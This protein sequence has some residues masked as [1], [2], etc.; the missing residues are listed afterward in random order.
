MA[1][2]NFKSKVF[3]DVYVKDG[4]DFKFESY[5]ND[6]L[7]GARNYIPIKY[8]HT[9][10]NYFS[11]IYAN[12]IVHASED[13]YAPSE[14]VINGVWRWKLTMADRIYDRVKVETVSGTEFIKTFVDKTREMSKLRLK[15]FPEIEP[16][17]HMDVISNLRYSI[18]KIISG[19]AGARLKIEGP[20]GLFDYDGVMASILR[21]TLLHIRQPHYSTARAPYVELKSSLFGSG[22]FNNNFRLLKSRYKLSTPEFPSN[23]Y[24]PVI[25]DMKINEGVETTIINHVFSDVET[26]KYNMSEDLLINALTKYDGHMIIEPCNYYIPLVEQGGEGRSNF[27]TYCPV[28]DDE[29]YVSPEVLKDPTVLLQYSLR[30]GEKGNINYEFVKDTMESINS[31]RLVNAATK[32]FTSLP[33]LYGYTLPA[34]LHSSL[35]LEE[36]QKLVSGLYNV[37]SNA[38]KYDAG[39]VG[40][41]NIISDVDIT[42]GLKGDALSGKFRNFQKT[43]SSNSQR[44][45]ISGLNNVLMLANGTYKFIYPRVQVLDDTVFESSQGLDLSVYMDRNFIY[46][47]P[48]FNDKTPIDCSGT[49]NPIALT[50]LFNTNG[51]RVVE[52]HDNPYNTVPRIIKNAITYKDMLVNLPPLST[53]SYPSTEVTAGTDLTKQLWSLPSYSYIN[54]LFWSNV[55]VVDYVNVA[56]FLPFYVLNNTDWHNGNSIHYEQFLKS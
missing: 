9:K 5:L 25:M 33:S 13:V 38:P 56:C 47:I 54:W 22:Y 40:V 49:V 2:P 18:Y 31:D 14:Q 46:E 16:K 45:S 28:V 29:V 6:S 23:I 48:A 35:E 43:S 51:I 55:N 37:S 27:S 32:C 52:L 24:N 42:V 44:R 1:L 7:T 10:F 11:Y 20:E 34:S 21:P 15:K 12:A 4:L 19:P 36:Q 30:R 39:M 3:N 50:D 26:E 53:L 17:R 8:D 41:R